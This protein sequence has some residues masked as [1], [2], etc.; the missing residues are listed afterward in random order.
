MRVQEEGR[1]VFGMDNQ[2]GFSPLV[3]PYNFCFPTRLSSLRS[4]KL[5]N[6][7]NPLNPRQQLQID[8]SEVVCCGKWLHAVSNL[9]N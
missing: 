9:R 6:K 2:N 4:L 5:N 8:I 1:M 3:V 7:I